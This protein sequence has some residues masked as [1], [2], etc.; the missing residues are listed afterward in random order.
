VLHDIAVGPFLEQPAGKVAAPF[1]V[2]GAADVELHKGPGFLHIFPRSGR[3]ARLQADDGVARAQGVA[4]LHGEVG[5]DAV[6]LVEQADDGDALLHGSAGQG[7]G[8]SVAD[9]LA[10]DLHRS[11]LVGGR[12]FVAAARDQHRQGSKDRPKAQDRQG[13]P[14]PTPDHDASGLHAS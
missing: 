11:C 1:I 5:G 13:R 8:V 6:A 9:L 4:R 12:K 2:G 10:L 3:L 14:R 7:R